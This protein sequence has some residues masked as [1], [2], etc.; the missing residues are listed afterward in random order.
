MEC[1][2]LISWHSCLR[3]F[4]QEEQSLRSIS[5]TFYRKQH[6]LICFFFLYELLVS[7]IKFT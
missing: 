4:H 6:S 3:F 5:M 7:F 2:H 1:K